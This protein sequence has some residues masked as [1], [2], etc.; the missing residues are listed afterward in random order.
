M[1]IAMATV[2]FRNGIVSNAPGGRYELNLALVALAFAVALLGTGRLSLDAVLRTRWARRS[3]PIPASVSDHHY[4][5]RPDRVA[6]SP[7]RPRSTSWSVRT[8]VT[9]STT[10]DRRCSICSLP[11]VRLL[12]PTGAGLYLGAV[13]INI[14]AFIAIVGLL[15]LRCRRQIARWAALYL[16]VFSIFLFGWS[17]MASSQETVWPVAAMGCREVEL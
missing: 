14:A 3:G 2:T 7:G 13:V 1:V 9:A 17:A 15:W 11:F 8:A 6:A 16:E 12:G 10:P 5:Q 4:D